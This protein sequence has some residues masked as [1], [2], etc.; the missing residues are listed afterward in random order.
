MAEEE[1]S[2]LIKFINYDGGSDLQTH[3]IRTQDL[4]RHFIDLSG[5]GITDDYLACASKQ[6]DSSISEALKKVDSQANKNVVHIN[7]KDNDIHIDGA[8]RIFEHIGNA[9]NLTRLN[10]LNLR[11]NS[12]CPLKSKI[13]AFNCA[14]EKVLRKKKTLTVDISYNSIA[15]SFWFLDFES[16]YGKEVSGRIIWDGVGR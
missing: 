9:D 4:D 6:P 14:L 7:L 11:W 1:E 12:I 10:M 8:K 5:R 16:A 2:D 3:N 13:G 15:T